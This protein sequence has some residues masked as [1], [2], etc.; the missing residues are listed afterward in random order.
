[1]NPAHR[2]LLHFTPKRNWMNDP[3]GLVYFDETYHLYFQYNPEGNDWGN[4]SWG[5]A[6][7]PDLVEWTEHDIAIPCRPGEQI[8]SG[9]IVVDH[10]NTSGFGAEDA[11]PLIAIYTSALDDGRQAQSLAISL[12]GGYTWRAHDDNPV[13]DRGSKTFRDPKVFRAA[14][15]EGNERWVMVAVEAEARQVVVYSSATLRDWKY[16]SCFG[17]TGPAGVQWE[18]PDLFKLALDADPQQKRWILII[19]TNPGGPAGGSVTAY[20]VGDFDGHTFT[21]GEE[22]RWRFVDQGH[23]FYAAVTFDNLPAE[24]RTLIGWASNWDYAAQV[25]TAPWRGAMSIARRLSLRNIEGVPTLIQAPTGRLE[26]GAPAFE[27]GPAA[28]EDRALEFGAGQNFLLDVEWQID[29]EAVVGIDLLANADFRTRLRYDTRT[30]E[31]TLDRAASGNTAFHD[32]F[33]TVSRAQLPRRNGRIGLQILVDGSILEIFAD[34]GALTMTE[35]VFPDEN[36]EELRLVVEAGQANAT[37]KWW[38]LRAQHDTSTEGIELM[39]AAR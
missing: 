12:D 8:F 7:S 34:D 21:V 28:L 27:F 9:S 11:I 2:P 24:Q 15:R 3:N 30:E 1:M 37:L 4:M 14:D 17:P 29:D 10:G 26:V 16:E 6:T 5:H 20:L 23:D 36:A 31:L 18:C 32:G 13:L 33:A 25:P 22:S 19:S 35:L 39:D 38:P